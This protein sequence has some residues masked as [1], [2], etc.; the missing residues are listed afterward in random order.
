MSIIVRP[1]E[2]TD[3]IQVRDLLYVDDLVDLYVAA[4]D[5]IDKVS[6]QVFNA[7]GGMNNSLS[8]LE[9]LGM[10][11]TDLKMPMQYTFSDWRPGDQPIFVS[12]NGKAKKFLG[13]EPKTDVRI[14]IK[15]LVD[16]LTANK[17][18]LEQFYKR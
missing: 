16:W 17:S 3:L 12:D 13:W 10:I 11:D 18:M 8:L 5:N 14:G 1:E 9:F 6:G 4:V 7:G 15:N 2:I